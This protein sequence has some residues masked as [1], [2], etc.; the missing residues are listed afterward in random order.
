VS[1]STALVPLTPRERT[2][3]YAG[4]CWWTW[5][6]ETGPHTHRICNGCGFDLLEGRSCAVCRATRWEYVC[7]L[8]EVRELG[9]TLVPCGNGHLTPLSLWACPTCNDALWAEL[10]E[11]REQLERFNRAALDHI[12]LRTAAERVLNAARMSGALGETT[13][14]LPPVLEAQLRELG[15]VLEDA[16]GRLLERVREQREGRAA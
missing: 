4:F 16:V 7:D 1:G 6:H 5:C 12:L 14:T 8:E 2:S 13:S 11:A 9:S 15:L 10:K 3:H